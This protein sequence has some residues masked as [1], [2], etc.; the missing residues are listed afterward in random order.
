LTLLPL[1]MDYVI[2]IFV[3]AM[4]ITFVFSLVVILG[5][6]EGFSAQ[7]QW[8]SQTSFTSNSVSSSRVLLHYC[9]KSSSDDSTH[10]NNGTN[11]N[12][13]STRKQKKG[14]DPQ[15]FLDTSAMLTDLDDEIA[16]YEWLDTL[17]K[18][19]RSEPEWIQNDV[20]TL[21]PSTLLEEHLES[22][23]PV[24][25]IRPVLF[26][27]EWSR[28]KFDF[29]WRA[30]FLKSMPTSALN[31]ILHNGQSNTHPLRLQLVAIPPQT[32]LQLHCHPACE[33]D[34]PLLGQLYERAT[35]ITIPSDT[36][37]RRIDQ[38]I[39]TP[40]S[41]FSSRPTPTELEQIA[42]DLSTRIKLPDYG[43]S[44][45]FVERVI[46]NGQC[47]VNLPGSIHQSFT[48][49]EKGG[50][51]LWVLGPNVHAHF[52]PGTFHQREGIDD[53]TDIDDLI[54]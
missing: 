13:Y 42:H 16:L 24:G 2:P 46:L 40:L 37:Q 19:E 3:Y 44:G 22:L 51:L 48:K 34:I 18:V 11:N 32:S 15:Y 36:L 6:C 7:P 29:D 5:G 50:C 30:C 52:L 4:K 47:L 27:T 33:L 9:S 25:T 20:L 38:Q 45:R 26:P 53:L 12:L 49:K 1:A 10:D 14:G 21:S 39:G 23:L 35:L 43:P 31:E 28:R 8:Q 41:N 17:K 54:T